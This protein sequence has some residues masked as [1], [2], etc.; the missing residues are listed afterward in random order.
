MSAAPAQRTEAPSVTNPL[1][2][3]VIAFPLRQHDQTDGVLMWLTIE[4]ANDDGVEGYRIAERRHRDRS[5]PDDRSV[6]APRE[7]AVD[8]ARALAEAEAGKRAHSIGAGGAVTA[9]NLAHIADLPPGWAIAFIE[10]LSELPAGYVVGWAREKLGSMQLGPTDDHPAIIERY[11]QRTLRTCAVCG[12]PGR[13]MQ[14]GGF[15]LP[16][17]AACGASKGFT[18]PPPRGDA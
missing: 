4:R 5:Y 2:H 17:C 3:Q 15:H 6:F 1:E 12:A 10:M 8:L 9:A 11:R 16:H 18:D 7:M 14:R 13:L